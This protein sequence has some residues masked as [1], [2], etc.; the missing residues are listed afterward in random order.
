M[1]VRAELEAFILEDIALGREMQSID[2]DEDLLARGVIDS[3]AVTQLVA[4][5]EERYSILITDEELVPDNFRSLAR[6]AAFVE[7]KRPRAPTW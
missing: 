6:M 4:F 1:S 7:R 3:L 2:P 5:L